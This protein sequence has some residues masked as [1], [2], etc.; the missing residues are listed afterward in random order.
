[1]HRFRIVLGGLL[2]AAVAG[3]LARRAL[4]VVRIEGESMEPTFRSGD[5]TLAIRARVSP[6]IRRGD[7]VVCRLPP[8]IPGPT[9]YLVKRV[10]A[11][12][13]DPVPGSNPAAHEVLAAGRIYLQGDGVRS[14]D[15]RKFGALPLAAVHGRVIARLTLA[16]RRPAE[17]VVVAF[18]SVEGEPCNI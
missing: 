3:M 17:R 9:G 4:F 8:E 12:A 18:E 7:V 11:V 1:M 2:S 10:A 14:Y 5:A 16:V 15:S 6:T 13:G